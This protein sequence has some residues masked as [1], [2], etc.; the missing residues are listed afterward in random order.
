[1]L[2][3]RH[4]NGHGESSQ[5]QPQEESK[6]QHPPTEV[7]DEE[8]FSTSTNKTFPHQTIQEVYLL[9]LA[10]FV[11]M[12]IIYCLLRARP[13]CPKRYVDGGSSLEG[14][15]EDADNEEEPH[16]GEGGHPGA[17]GTLHE[18]AGL[19]RL[20][21]SE[22]K[23]VMERILKRRSYKYSSLCD[24]TTDESAFSSIGSPGGDKD[25][26]HVKELTNGD[27]EIGG[28]KLCSKTKYDCLPEYGNEKEAAIR[29]GSQDDNDHGIGKICC[30]C[31]NAY[32][33]GDWVVKGTQ[34]RHVCHLQCCQEWLL[35]QNNCPYCRVEVVQASEFRDAAVEVLGHKRVEVAHSNH[36]GIVLMATVVD[37]DPIITSYGRSVSVTEESSTSAQRSN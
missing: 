19:Y 37:A 1:M 11:I 22:R 32:E 15:V 34:C 30:I 3:F 29:S 33:N 4:L 2:L 18:K 35:K 36:S 8:E 12:I 6:I 16:Y 20:R 10:F 9:C 7:H 23:L 13:C 31:L 14:Q 5:Q 21:I 26:H 17:G 25:K 28:L 24:S 27:I